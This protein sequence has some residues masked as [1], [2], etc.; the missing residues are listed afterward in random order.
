MQLNASQKLAKLVEEREKCGCVRCTVNWSNK[1]RKVDEHTSGHVSLFV[2]VEHFAYSFA[3][4]IY[5][6]GL[7]FSVCSL[8]TYE[9]LI[10]LR[11]RAFA[12][13]SSIISI[14]YTHCHR[15][16]S[17]ISNPNCYP[18]FST[19]RSPFFFVFDFHFC[20]FLFVRRTCLCALLIQ[21][22]SIFAFVFCCV[23]AILSV[24]SLVWSFVVC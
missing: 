21:S 22:N 12:E 5:L 6:L 23:A 11:A 13:W 18:L 9:N 3:R 24:I 15:H 7:S 10:G 4:W 14:P 17:I 1:A 2:A 8:K 16:W 20:L 19:H